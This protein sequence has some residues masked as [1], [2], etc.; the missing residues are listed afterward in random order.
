M[1]WGL[2]GLLGGAVGLDA[3]SFPQVMI[4]R[5]I[6]AGALAGLLLRAPVEGALI[7]AFLEIFN[8]AIL[9]IGAARYP[10]AGTAAVAATA[11][12]TAAPP[13]TS[14]SAA[15]VLAIAFALAWE[16][17]SG[18]SVI[19]FR[20]SVERLLFKDGTEPDNPT[21]LE[22]RHLTAIGIDG[23]RG[24][25]LSLS[26]AFL[27]TMLLHVSAPFWQIPAVT[28]RGVLAIAGAAVLAGTLTVFGGWT[29]QRRL[30]LLG[31][32]C[33]SILLALR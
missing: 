22:R 33:G 24:A 20:R 25:V 32:L 23:L 29:L 12:F 10:E 18:A 31:A 7:G 4:S 11:A 3:T 1:T 21:H 6:V 16:R 2:I 28:T 14:Q 27:A 15:L 8:L 5:P 17:V 26:G 30:F 13:G 19:L 9:P